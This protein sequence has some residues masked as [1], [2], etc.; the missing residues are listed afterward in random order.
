MIKK[1]QQISLMVL[2]RNPKFTLYFKVFYFQSLIRKSPY[3]KIEILQSSGNKL[4]VVDMFAIKK[5]AREFAFLFVQFPRFC[6]SI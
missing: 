2:T 1:M 5:I 6:I 4:N 3:L